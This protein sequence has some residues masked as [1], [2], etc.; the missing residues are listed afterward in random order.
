MLYWL[1]GRVKASREQ[2]A[3]GS[4]L[5]SLATLPLGT[6]RAL[7]LVRVGREVVVLGV[8]EHGVSPVRTYTE[9]AALQAGLVDPQDDDPPILPAQRPAPAAPATAR[10]ALE[11]LRRRTVRK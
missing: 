10:D 3:S 8:G 11:A 1:L 4:G 9:Q 2:Q 5:S 6:G 7:H